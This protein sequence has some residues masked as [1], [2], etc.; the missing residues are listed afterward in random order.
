MVILILQKEHRLGVIIPNTDACMITTV[1][2]IGFS[3]GK[4]TRQNAE[5][6]VQPSITAASSTD[7]FIERIKP[8]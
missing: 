4:V 5:N 3:R 1:A 6:L 8:S 2:V 7:W